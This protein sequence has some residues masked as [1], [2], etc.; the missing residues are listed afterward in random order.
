[1]SQRCRYPSCHSVFYRNA[2]PYYFVVMLAPASILVGWAFAEISAITR[3]QASEWVTSSLV[4]VLWLGTVFNGLRYLDRLVFDDQWLQREVIAGIHQIFP[5]PVSYI[6][7]CGMVSSF[8]KAGFFM[9]TWG[10][11]VYRDR[12]TA[13]MPSTLALQEPAFVLVNAP[14]LSPSY[15]GQL[16][17]LA[18]DQELLA[19]HYVDYWG[20]VRVAG[21]DVTLAAST[22]LRVTRAVRFKVPTRYH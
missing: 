9:S 11:E 1:M 15:E 21:A 19:K 10:L 3:R 13:V 2:F 16:G 4:A 20:P 8:T 5:E 6:D 22:A 14:A 12:N 18:E 7:R 17:L